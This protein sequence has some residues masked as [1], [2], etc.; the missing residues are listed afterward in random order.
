MQDLA[1]DPLGLDAWLAVMAAE[2]LEEFVPAGGGALR[3][4][5]APDPLIAPAIAQLAALARRHGLHPVAIDA[6]HTRLHMLQDV[7]F[8]LA[9]ALPWSAMAQA[10]VERLFAANAMAWPCPGK[11]PGRAGLAA[12]LGLAPPLL[13]RRIDAWLTGAIWH[14]R[15]YALDFRGALFTLCNAALEADPDAA[16][17]VLAWLRGAKVPLGSLRASGI[18][19][20]ITRATARAMLISICHFVRAAGAPGILLG[21]DLRRLHRPGPAPEGELRYSPATVLDTYEVLRELIDD[22]EHLPGLFVAVLAGPEL[23]GGEPRR[24]LDQ[25]DALRLRVWPDVRPGRGQ[26]PLAP[27]VWLGA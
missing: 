2:Y 15:A 22:A 3:I 11:A 5:V 23:I 18:G 25:Y 4:A 9:R 12:A 14:T 26:N 6:A 7:V 8:A 24:T 27:L 21:I 19:G 13:N 1:P 17:P 20:R 16:E 10:F